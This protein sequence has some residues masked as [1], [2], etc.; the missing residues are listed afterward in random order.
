VLALEHTSSLFRGAAKEKPALT[1]LYQCIK[2]LTKVK[3]E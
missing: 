2:E 3:D 1:A